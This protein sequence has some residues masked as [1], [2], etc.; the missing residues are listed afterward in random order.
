MSC[1]NSCA[2]HAAGGFMTGIYE[3]RYYPAGHDLYPATSR[4][5]LADFETL[6]SQGLIGGL[7]L[8]RR[9]IGGLGDI[10]YDDEGYA[11]TCDTTP[12]YQDPTESPYPV[13]FS[14][15]ISTTIPA[16]TL[17]VS[18]STL[19]N[20]LASWSATAQQLLKVAGGVAQPTYVQTTPQGG[21]TTVYGSTAAPLSTS[22]ASLGSSSLVVLGIA[23]IVI[24]AIAKGGK[25]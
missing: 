9:G 5:S 13:V 25:H 16:G 24:L 22:I 1:C 20:L 17:A 7:G 18:N 15:P 3:P 12:V 6:L 10:C 14:N 2:D 23:A 21:S 4:P 8:R 19:N 11:V